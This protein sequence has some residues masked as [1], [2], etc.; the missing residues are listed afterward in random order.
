MHPS[1]AL[2]ARARGARRS[3]GPL[4]L[5]VLA[6][7][8]AQAVVARAQEP[9][10]TAPQ[11]RQ[12]AATDPG[13]RVPPEVDALALDTVQR[14]LSPPADGPE[15][16]LDATFE[17]LEEHGSQMLDVVCGMLCGEVPLEPVDAA[18]APVQ[19]HPRMLAA[20]QELMR[21]YV[22]SCDAATVVACLRA[23][24]ADDAPLDVRVAAVR[25]LGEVAD[26]GALDA[27]M[28]LAA[29]VEPAYLERS[30]VQ[31]SLQTALAACI[32]RAERPERRLEEVYRGCESRLRALVVR[33]AGEASTPATTR[34]L[35]SLI[36]R[37][38]ALDA[39]VVGELAREAARQPVTLDARALDALRGEL[40]RAEPEL[41]RVC[42]AALGALGDADAVEPLVGLLASSDPLESIT[43]HRSLQQIC[44]ADLG[45]DPQA[46]TRW[47]D[48]EET[49]WSDDAPRELERLQGNDLAAIHKAIGAL[50]RHPLRRHESAAAIAPLLGN[51]DA[52]VV[53]AAR[54]ALERLDSAAALP[55]LVDALADADDAGREANA[56][57]LR[58]LTGLDLPAD[59]LAW[60]RALGLR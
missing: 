43:V 27:L 14:L 5:A 60:S 35:A 37:A 30:Y 51:Q 23:R 52:G 12:D 45:V 21:R 29:G 40:H 10:F 31:A 9:A 53:A 24:G 44:G 6:L 13:A 15:P 59:Y 20:R 25:L 57:L 58:K 17:A 50:L 39:L 49:W 28:E 8:A 11:A 55:G 26:P 47:L 48:G 36:G 33:A 54:R 42:A 7:S 22:A 41:R 16:D 56:R 38:G 4:A 19:V 2:P 34:F 32:V 1:R 18:G 46:W 3:P